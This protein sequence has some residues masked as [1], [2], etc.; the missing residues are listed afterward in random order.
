MFFIEFLF[1]V[2]F[3]FIVM[4]LFILVGSRGP[5]NNLGLLFVVVLLVSWAGGMWITPMGP[6]VFGREWVPFLI[7]AGLFALFLVNIVP[8]KDKEVVAS[9][10]EKIEK[11]DPKNIKDIA[12]LG[13]AFWVFICALILSIAIA[14]IV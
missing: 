14:Y 7:M 9:P 1:A 6:P 8:H 4:A 3:S 2:F 13:I 5:W 10:E 12:T 11:G